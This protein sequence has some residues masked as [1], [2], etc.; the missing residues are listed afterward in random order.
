MCLAAM[1]GHVAARG[2]I[3]ARVGGSGCLAASRCCWPMPH[4]RVGRARDAARPVDAIAGS[5]AVLSYG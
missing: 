1:E 2:A 3:D 4:W 5:L